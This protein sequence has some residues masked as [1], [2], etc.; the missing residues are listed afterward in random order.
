MN[1]IA[2][3]VV[4]PLVVATFSVAAALPAA[5]KCKNMGFL[6][7]DYGKE[8]PTRDAKRLLDKHIAK[9]AKEN[10]ISKYTVGKKTVKCELFLDF[11][12]FDEHTCTARANVCWGSRKRSDA[13]P[14]KKKAT[15]VAKTEENKAE[16]KPA[17]DTVEAAASTPASTPVESTPASTPSTPPAS[18]P[19]VAET[20]PDLKPTQTAAEPA[21]KNATAAEAVPAPVPTTEPA[22]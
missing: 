2:K 1:S 19:A 9:W 18:T 15:A 5:A 12:F 10:G 4:V 13:K 20:T 16:P 8:G 6:V 3:F 14:A 17:T 21:E 7:N 11:G 22:Q